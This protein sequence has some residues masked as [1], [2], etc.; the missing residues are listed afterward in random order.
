MKNRD[1]VLLNSDTVDGINA[2]IH[3]NEKENFCGK[4]QTDKIRIKAVEGGY[5]DRGKKARMHITIIS[6]LCKCPSVFVICHYAN[7]SGLY[8]LQRYM[9]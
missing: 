3:Y 4:P 6:P 9:P 8:C 5:K 1:E 7:Q 2:A